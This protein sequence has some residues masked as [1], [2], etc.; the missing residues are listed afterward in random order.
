MCSKKFKKIIV[1]LISISRIIGSILMPLFFHIFDIPILIT[2]IIILFITDSL[3]GFFARRWHVQTRGGALLDPLGD[4]LL[5]VSCTLS[6]VYKHPILLLLLALEIV[7]MVL[8]I[9]R[10]MHGEKSVTLIIGKVKMWLLSITLVLCAI[11]SLKSDFLSTLNITITYETIIYSSIVTV[12]F[13]LITIYFYLNDSIRQKD[14]RI[15]KIPNLK[16]FKD[17]LNILFDESLYEQDKDKPLI[18]VIKQ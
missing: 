13:Q 8:N 2:I 5:A 7:T 12:L 17:I 3:D 11:Y 16:N 15:N 6:F 1:N 4:K 10:A 18:E 9:S 14:I